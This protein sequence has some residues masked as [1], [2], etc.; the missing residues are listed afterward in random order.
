MKTPITTASLAALIAVA[1][2]QLFV[3]ATS[4]AAPANIDVCHVTPGLSRSGSGR[5][6]HVIT[7]P[8]SAL[9]AHA[10]HGDS[11]MFGRLHTGPRDCRIIR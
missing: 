6:G 3:P 5:E 10:R 9:S 8:E 4:D 1:G 2:F 11:T 7:I